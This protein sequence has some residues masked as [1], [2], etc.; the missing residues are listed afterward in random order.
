ML[1]V[2]LQWVGTLLGIA[3]GFLVPQKTNRARR[4]GFVLWIISDLAMIWVLKESALWPSMLMF[5]Y[6]T[7]SS[8]LGW[9]NNRK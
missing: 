1:L 2:V 3:G 5:T 8:G 4:W 6:F 9:W 7:A